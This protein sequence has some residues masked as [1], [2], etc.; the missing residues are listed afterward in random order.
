MCDGAI[1]Y[2]QATTCDLT[3]IVIEAS[4]PNLG[5]QQITVKVSVD[6]ADAVLAV[7][8]GT[9]TN[10]SDGFSYVDSFVG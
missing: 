7:A 5:P 4:A 3:P 8:K 1:N 2:T 6:A 10:F 9:A